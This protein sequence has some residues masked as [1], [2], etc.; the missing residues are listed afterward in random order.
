MRLRAAA[1]RHRRVQVVRLPARVRVVLLPARVQAAP[2]PARA[3]V[4]VLLPAAVQVVPLPAVLEADRS[5]TSTGTL[6]RG[7]RGCLATDT[8]RSSCRT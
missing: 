1:R 7:I 4:V 5:I 6:H 3:Q 2:L 8:R